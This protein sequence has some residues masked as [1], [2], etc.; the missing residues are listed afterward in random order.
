MAAAVAAHYCQ[1]IAYGAAMEQGMG[2][3]RYVHPMEIAIGTIL[4]W[5]LF[6]A[7]IPERPHPLW[8]GWEFRGRRNPP[9]GS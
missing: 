1:S 9:L 7:E 8:L 2:S 6:P 4:S 3:P 5:P